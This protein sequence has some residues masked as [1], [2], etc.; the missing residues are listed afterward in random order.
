MK[1]TVPI[2]PYFRNTA[3]AEDIERCL[4]IHCLWTF[5]V[6]HRETQ[7]AIAKYCP[8]P[9][10]TIA[11]SLWSWTFTIWWVWASFHMLAIRYRLG[12]FMALAFLFVYIKI[13]FNL[14][15]QYWLNEY[16]TNLGIGVY[17]SGVEIF[18]TEF[19]YGRRDKKINSHAKFYNLLSS[20]SSLR[21]PSIFVQWNLWNFASRERRAWRAIPLQV[22]RLMRKRV[23]LMRQ[24]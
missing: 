10:W 9:T 7:E 12:G 17:H 14:H 13:T 6:S 8:Q 4:Q 19:A 20:L 24:I 1:R 23:S 21:W 11:Q 2:L 15:P 18:N 22:E 16:T 3:R 5:H